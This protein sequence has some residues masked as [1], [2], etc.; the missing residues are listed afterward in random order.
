NQYITN[1]YRVNP[2]SHTIQANLQEAPMI[3]ILQGILPSSQEEILCKCSFEESNTKSCLVEESYIV[4]GTTCFC[5]GGLN[6]LC[7]FLDKLL[8]KSFPFIVQLCIL[9]FQSV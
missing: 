6:I 8:S 4:K 9:I 3:F 2:E 7:Y 1:A 5:N